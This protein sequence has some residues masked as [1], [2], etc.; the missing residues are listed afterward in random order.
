[1][2]SACTLIMLAI[3]IASVIA[4]IGRVIVMLIRRW[5]T[6]GITGSVTKARLSKEVMEA[7]KNIL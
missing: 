5:F 4:M 1:M 7:V 2:L 3:I 6:V